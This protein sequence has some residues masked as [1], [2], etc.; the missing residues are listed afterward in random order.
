MTLHQQQIRDEKYLVL[1]LSVYIAQCAANKTIKFT[2]FHF[3][4]MSGQSDDTRRSKE[5]YFIRKFK[6]SLNST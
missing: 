1:P 6:P 4:K 5:Q 3:Y 2:V